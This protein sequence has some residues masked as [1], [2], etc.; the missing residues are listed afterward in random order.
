MTLVFKVPS[1]LLPCSLDLICATA[2]VVSMDAMFNRL[3]RLLCVNSY[4]ARRLLAC[5]F[6]C[7]PSH[8]LFLVAGGKSI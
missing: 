1:H 4:N 6:V 7:S 5:L 2:N 3:C 8:D